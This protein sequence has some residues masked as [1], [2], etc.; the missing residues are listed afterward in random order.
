MLAG[1]ILA[2]FI[3]TIAILLNVIPAPHKNLDY[4]VIGAIATFLA[5]TVLWVVLMQGWLGPQASVV[6]PAAPEPEAEPEP[7]A[8][9]PE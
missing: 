6:Q 7:P 9:T 5:M 8:P 2:L 4:L 1:G 3:A